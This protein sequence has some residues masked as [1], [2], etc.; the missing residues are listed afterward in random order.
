MSSKNEPRPFKPVVGHK[1]V[2]RPPIGWRPSPRWAPSAEGAPAARLAP[3]L[4]DV[5]SAEGCRS[6]LAHDPSIPSNDARPAGD[7]IDVRMAEIDRILRHAAM[8][9]LQKCVL[10]AEW[11]HHAEAKL[12]VV[13]QVVSKPNPKAVLPGL[14]ANCACLGQPQQ[15]AESTSTAPSRLPRSGPRQNPRR[16]P[17]DST[18]FN[19]PFSPLLGSVR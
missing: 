5:A 8:R 17:P 4:T 9:H 2:G 1:V 13:G 12:S 16:K 11:V 10:A 6:D 18:T 7:E 15:H 19:P 14:R 3:S